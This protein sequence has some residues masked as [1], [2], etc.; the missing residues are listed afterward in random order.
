MFGD[1]ILSNS[2]TLNSSTTKGIAGLNKI[3]INLIKLRP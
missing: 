2:I 3:I 1:D